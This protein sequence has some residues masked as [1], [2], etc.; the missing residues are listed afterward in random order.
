MRP[1]VDLRSKLV[2]DG[3][4]NHPVGGLPNETGDCRIALILAAAKSGRIIPRPEA[5]SGHGG[6]GA[7]AN[8]YQ[9]FG[10]LLGKHKEIVLFGVL[11]P[12]VKAH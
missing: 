6:R 2:R 1:L 10:G 9:L 5:K 12:K 11:K 8:W 4:N 3:A 7:S